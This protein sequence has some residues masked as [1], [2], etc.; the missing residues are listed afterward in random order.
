MAYKIFLYKKV[1]DETDEA[2]YQKKKM[3]SSGMMDLALLSAN[4][5]QLRHTL[6]APDHQFYF[7][8]LIL[9]I[10]SLI[11]Q[12][13]VGILL[14][15]NTNYTSPK[16]GESRGSYANVLN[17]SITAGVLLISAINVFISAFGVSVA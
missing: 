11:I 17:N 13:T 6:Q 3:L 16:R 12:V 8:S 4:A 5:N 14:I 15:V 7:M 10:T 2:K 1:L 9:I